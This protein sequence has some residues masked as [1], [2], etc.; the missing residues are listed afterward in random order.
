MP[1]SHPL[2]GSVRIPG[3]KSITHRAIL[4]S[5]LAKGTSRIDGYLPSDDCLRTVA[6]FRQMGVAFEAFVRDG[7]PTLRVTGT[8][9]L[10]EPSD[11]ID[12]GNSGTTIRLLTGLL[13]GQPFFSVLTGD[14]SLRRR[15]M[16]R[17][18]GPL[19]RM[20]AVISGRADDHLAPLAICGRQLF[21]TDHLLP[22]ASAQVKSAL[23]LAGLTAN[24]V[25][26][27]REPASSRDHTE[28]ML[29]HFGHPCERQDGWISVQGGGTLTGVDMA[30]PGDFSSAAFFLVAG[31][32]VEGSEIVLDQIGVNPTRTGLIDTLREMGADIL[33]TP[34]ASRCGEPVAQINV[35]W[36]RLRGTTVSRDRL[37][38]MIDE[39]PIF[40]VAAAMA[41]GETVIRGAEE[42]RVKESDRI[43]AMAE[44]LSAVGVTAEALPDGIRIRGGRQLVGGACRT[45][46]DHRVAMAM[47][48]AAL[49]A[50]GPITLNDIDSIQTSFPDFMMQL[51]SLTSPNHP[52][53]VL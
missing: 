42:L 13:A 24:G 7:T 45:H 3:D 16:R 26:R 21:G 11:V 14:A 9:R 49:V 36:R 29:S 12:C 53:P 6:A 18:I 5:A 31:A 8:G 1:V 43:A 39:F 51:A 38:S 37:L 20:G 41:E 28:R 35:R 44:A 25:T 40:C 33:L 23:L 47:S 34:R 48:I 10:S 52:Q 30:I 27:V 4:F 22:F 46:G 15:P 17:V 2:R 50:D 32:V 19:R